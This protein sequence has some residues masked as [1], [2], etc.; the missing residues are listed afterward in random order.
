M[1]VRAE[2][3]ESA[4]SRR[5]LGGEVGEGDNEEVEKGSDS[6]V[7]VAIELRE[8]EAEGGG[9]GIFLAEMLR[10]GLLADGELSAR[11]V[12]GRR[13]HWRLFVDV[14]YDSTFSSIL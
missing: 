2:V 5:Q 9:R 12:I 4:S 14:C 10:E 11:L 1:G 3:E 8:D 7:E 13:W 6:W